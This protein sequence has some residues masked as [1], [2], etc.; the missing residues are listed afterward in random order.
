MGRGPA[1]AR[2][3]DGHHDPKPHP[4]LTPDERAQAI[5]QGIE[6]RARQGLGRYVTDPAALD[7]FA[8]LL[9]RIT[10]PAPR[11]DRHP[12]SPCPPTSTAAPGCATD[13]PTTPPPSDPDQLIESKVRENRLRRMAQRQGL[14]L[15]KSRRRDPKAL[16]YG[17]F[18]LV[19]G[20]AGNRI[21]NGEGMTLDEVEQALRE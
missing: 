14:R 2:R 20:S 6:S 10:P 4:V 9:A 21:A 7:F 1:F 17:L 12:T 8:A 19:R 3:G 16:D 5:A 15:I 11:S 13:S 18:S